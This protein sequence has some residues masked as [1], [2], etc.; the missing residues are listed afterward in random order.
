MTTTRI[1]MILLFLM[2]NEFKF[3][4]AIFKVYDFLFFLGLYLAVLLLA[5]VDVDLGLNISGGVVGPVMIFITMLYM[6]GVVLKR[7]SKK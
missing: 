2:E 6:Y 7:K 3:G 4:K 5:V 1:D